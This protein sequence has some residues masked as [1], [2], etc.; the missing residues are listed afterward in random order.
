M[1][2]TFTPRKLLLNSRKMAKTGR[3]ISGIN[4]FSA[5]QHIVND[6]HR[7]IAG[8]PI[9]DSI[10]SARKLCPDPDI[11]ES[12]PK[13]V[14]PI[15]TDMTAFYIHPEA[16][17]QRRIISHTITA[18]GCTD[19]KN[20][21]HYDVL[22]L[23]ETLGKTDLRNRIGF[24]SSKH[25]RFE[26]N[27][28]KDIPV[29]IAPEAEITVV[30]FEIAGT[31]GDGKQMLVFAKPPGFSEP[32]EITILKP[33]ALAEK[34]SNGWFGPLVCFFYATGKVISAAEKRR[35]KFNLLRIVDAK[36]IDLSDHYERKVFLLGT[37][38]EMRKSCAKII[39]KCQKADPDVDVVQ[40]S[41]ERLSEVLNQNTILPGVV[42][43]FDT[44]DYE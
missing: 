33:R 15:I 38:L 34:D 41:I 44:S 43:I 11:L 22:N 21:H 42:P 40:K 5:V 35:D 16:R 25:L 8:L 17:V 30:P 10:F 1:K 24:V 2:Q 36:D 3:I 6:R 13:E 19:A 7:L 29:H 32:V 37:F 20:C 39:S 26:G 18:N 12:F 28:K 14:S 31:L 27:T 23:P 9:V 4:F